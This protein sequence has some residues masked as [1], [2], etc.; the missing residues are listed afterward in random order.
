MKALIL[1]AGKGHRVRPLTDDVNKCMLLLNGQPILE[2]VIKNCCQMTN[3]DEIF[4]V[5]GYRAEDIVNY[6]GITY[7]GTKISYV[8]QREQKGLV[9]A[10]MCARSKIGDDDFFLLL[11]DEIVIGSEYEKLISLFQR[12]QNICTI[13]V[14]MVSDISR[15]KKTYTML[16]DDTNR[17]FRLIE[18]PSRPL[19]NLIGTGHVIFK[20]SIFD[21]I[22]NVPVNAIRGEKELPDL[23]QTAIDGGEKVYL[24]HFCNHYININELADLKLAEELLL[25]DPVENSR[26]ESGITLKFSDIQ[27]MTA[28]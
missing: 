14:S 19:N 16:H 3:I 24:S 4:I 23:I 5:V 15:I 6:F 26:R 22:E 8:I 21:Y 10:I 18:K 25:S 20:S 17:V 27:C 1:A 7:N 13:G 2:R 28:Q 11:G 9:D 12:E